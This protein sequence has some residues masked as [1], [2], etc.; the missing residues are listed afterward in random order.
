MTSIFE[1]I[2]VGYINPYKNPRINSIA[3][4][5]E[6]ISVFIM[7][8]IFCF[9][10]WVPDANTKYEIGF[11][12]LFFNGLHLLV[13]LLLILVDSYKKLRVSLLIFMHKKRLLKHRLISKTKIN[14]S[15]MIKRRHK[16]KFVKEKSFSFCSSSE[17]D[18][19]F[20]IVD[21]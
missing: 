18:W 6:V 5:N 17:D 16:M 10:E 14:A 13:N 19:E 20:G 4:I 8:H 21:A 1:V 9:T 15:E 2:L 3:I 12:C 7:Y 11:S